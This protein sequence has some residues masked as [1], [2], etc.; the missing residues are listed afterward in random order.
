MFNPGGDRVEGYTNFLWVILLAASARLGLPP[1]QVANPLSVAATIALMVV[2]FRFGRR[3]LEGSPLCLTAPLLLAVHRSFAAWSTSGLETRLFELLAVAGVLGLVESLERAPANRSV[4][5]VALLALAGLTRPDGALIAATALAGTAA[6]AYRYYGFGPNRRWLLGS[7]AVLALPL[8][9]HFAFRIMYYGVPLPN[10]YYAKV[11]GETWWTMGALYV[12]TFA[13]E[14]GLILWLPLLVAGIGWARR[15]SAD[16]WVITAAALLPHLVYVIS[17]G[18]DHFE[19][20][21]LDLQAPFLALAAQDGCARLIRAGR[22]V[23]PALALLGVSVLASTL[24]PALSHLDFPRHYIS[25][26]PS[27]GR[28]DGSRDLIRSDRLLARL[29]LVGTAIRAFNNRLVTMSRHFVGLRIEEHRLFA[30]R[31]IDEGKILRGWIDA[32]YLPAD[33]RI[34]LSCVGAIPYYSNLYTVDRLGL[35]DAF[36]AHLPFDR[37][38]IRAMAHSKTAPDDYLVEQ[39]VELSAPAHFLTEQDEVMTTWKLAREIGEQSIY[40]SP[41]PAGRRLF[42]TWLPQGLAHA[43]ARFPGLDLKPIIEF[44][45]PPEP[46]GFRTEEPPPKE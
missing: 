11:D 15:R 1:E 37:S 31:V 28:S 32:G 40:V 35:T 34:A 5:P 23:A 3:R 6:Q 13:L 21:P 14:Y 43:R 16:L 36:V 46:A 29:P 44:D 4:W 20:R 42:L 45:Q 27:H 18:G 22:R 9:A 41:R 8:A 26:F 24:L 38:R 39:G 25:G 33:A 7:L 12:A 17:I 30:D 10:T 2:I 19:W